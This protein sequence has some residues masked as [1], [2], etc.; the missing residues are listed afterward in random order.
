MLFF[1]NFFFQR[2]HKELDQGDQQ[3]AEKSEVHSHIVSSNFG[4][5]FH[6]PENILRIFIQD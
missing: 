1:T 2:P 6:D 3:S 5:M 4:V